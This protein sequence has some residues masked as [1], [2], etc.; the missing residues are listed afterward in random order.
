MPFRILIADDD[1]HTRRILETML[2]REPS[3]QGPEILTVTDGMEA[4]GALDTFAPD[5]VVSDLLMPRMDGFAF[6]RALRQH[7]L[8]S[9]LPLL[10]TSAIYKEEEQ[11]SE[12]KQLG[13]EFFA[14]PYQ[15]KDLVRAV[16]RILV[17]PTRPQ[18]A[19]SPAAP[20]ADRPEVPQV[21]AGSLADRGLPRLLFDLH[22][23]QATGVLS[24][25]RAQLRKQVFILLGHPIGADSNLRSETLGQLL[26][27]R[28]AVEPAA[29]A[30][31]LEESKSGRD[32]LGAVLVQR[33]ALKESEV[34][35]YLAT[36]V[37]LKIVNALRWQEGEYRFVAGDSFSGR[38]THLSVDAPR[39]VLSGLRRTAHAEEIARAAIAS[40]SRL[41]LGWRFSRHRDSFVRVFGDDKLPLLADRPRVRDLGLREDPELLAQYEAL[42]L[43][44][45][46]TLE[47]DDSVPQ[48]SAAATT[49][50]F[51]NPEEARREA[52]YL[53]LFGD[54]E[55]QQLA[56]MSRRPPMQELSIEDSGLYKLPQ[57][58]APPPAPAGA[59]TL[60]LRPS[61]IPGPE[62][63]GAREALL[64]H[65]LRLHG[66]THYDLLDLSR[67]AT[68]EEIEAAYQARLE[69]LRPERFAGI[70]LGR[71]HARLEEI[72]ARLQAAHQVLA[73]PARRSAYDQTLSPTQPKLTSALPIYE[74]E[75]HFREA[76]RLLA[77]E[78][79]AEAAARLEEAVRSAPE[80]ADYH[81]MLGWA[82]F[83]ARDP[84]APPSAGAQAARQALAQ[85]LAIDPDHAGGHEFSGRISFVLGED[86]DAI[87][88]LER[89]LRADPTRDEALTTLEAAC[90]RT[91]Q[92]QRLVG[93]LR[94]L[95]GR[96]GEARGT[97]LWH[98]LAV[99][100]RDQLGDREGARAALTTYVRLVP[101]DAGA[102]KALERLASATPLPQVEGGRRSA[103]ALRAAW[104]ADPDNLDA[105]RALFQLH[106]EAGQADRAL[107][108]AAALAARGAPDEDAAAYLRR[109]RPR[110]L[111]RAVA[112]VAW[113]QFD[114]LRHPDDD[115]DL[116][117]LFTRLF[118]AA[119]PPLETPL[120]AGERL[121][122]ESLP[123]AFS[124]VLGY[125]SWLLGVAP[126]AVLCSQAEGTSMRV[127]APPE[128]P[129]LL[130]VGP[131][132]LAINDKLPLAF[133]LGR[134]LSALYPARAQALALSSQRLKAYLAAASML[135][136][137]PPLGP[138]EDEARRLHAQ[139]AAAPQLAT[140]LRPLL[141]RLAARGDT[142]NLSRW[143]RGI[144]HTA[145]RIGLCACG[146]PVTAIKVLDEER[147]PA[148]DLIDFSL[149]DELQ[150]AR[151]AVGLTIAV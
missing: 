62:A 104:H 54:E 108:A 28:G 32:R 140:D 145:E 10:I 95:I 92:H 50:P 47:A 113:L 110:F 49:G 5:L 8:G 118:V 114:A 57:P 63:G 149:S 36:Q 20:A 53:E 102:R 124:Q 125:L 18:R 9:K 137:S 150:A 89:A 82:R 94:S 133:R 69:E 19:R 6:A 127:L 16:L 41:V 97:P 135:V 22:D 88:H 80:Q 128:E 23:A 45:L 147:L 75:E 37:R 117:A 29:L 58:P 25:S 39:V 112:Q 81:A 64:R 12:V 134:A 148:V 11:L 3:L 87:N 136:G 52:L 131:E 84:A 142:I 76:I 14:K 98:D 121:A 86:E 26:L 34:L 91:G 141:A 60:D 17:E 1:L 123:P 38:I 126:P 59:A 96:L 143:L 138:D 146:D 130:V 71:D 85:A 99:V 66:R 51:G 74:A 44:G 119:P 93:Q 72:H 40:R 70:D 31:A 42:V 65:Y 46:G 68:T 116:A 73:D 4:I 115:R 55:S 48:A 139:L 2:A 27:A 106:A 109:H 78:R 83:Q 90:L 111:Q 151:E 79:P 105:L 15:L 30:E 13:A 24:L 103:A 100:L 21:Q 7:P 67:D 61:L 120:P 129:P 101:D 56:E 107:A 132:A 33:G 35:T 122:A 144:G 77:A 43:S